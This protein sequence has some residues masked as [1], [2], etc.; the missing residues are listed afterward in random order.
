MAR[1]KVI[2]QSQPEKYYRKVDQRIAQALE[3]CFMQLETDPFFNPGKVKKLQGK[4][5]LYRYAVGGLRVIYAIDSANHK[6][7][8]ITIL[9]R[10]DIYKRISE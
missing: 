3:K 5:G 10:G 8:V 6:V 9:P 4:G 7:G 2:L 1:F